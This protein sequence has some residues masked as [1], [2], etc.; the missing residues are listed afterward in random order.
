MNAPLL[1]TCIENV[2][3]VRLTRSARPFDNNN[4]VHT[5][6]RN[7]ALVVFRSIKVYHEKKRLFHQPFPSVR[8]YRLLADAPS[9][10]PERV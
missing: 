6:S 7:V 3:R 2:N 5:T 8:N 10:L 9:A 1:G 4:Q